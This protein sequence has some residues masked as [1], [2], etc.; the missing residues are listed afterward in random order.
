MANYYALTSEPLPTPL[1]G[2]DGEYLIRTLTDRERLAIEDYFFK[3]NVQ[4]ALSP[5]ATAVIVPQDQTTSATMED[6]A[7]LVEFALGILTVS[8]FQPIMLVATLN[9][10][11][12]NEARQRSYREITGPPRFAKKVVKTAASTWVRYFFTAR[13]KAKDKL[14]I[15]A[16][17]FVRYLRQSNPLDALVDLCICLESL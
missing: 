4:I 6:F 14:H 7:V 8:G 3:S 12:C 17:R 5:S 13:R 1:H 15:T 10:F 11:T 16:D 2:A 9:A